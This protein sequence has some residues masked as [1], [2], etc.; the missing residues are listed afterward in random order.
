MCLNKIKDSLELL[1]VSNLTTKKKKQHIYKTK[2]N[3]RF[4][5]RQIENKKKI[6]QSLKGIKK[7][8]FL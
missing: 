1:N 5:G 6:K 3:Y 4:E 2:S 8:D 7:D